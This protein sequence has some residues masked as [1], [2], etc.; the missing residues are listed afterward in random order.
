MAAPK[1]KIP[2][3]VPALV[4]H[5]RSTEKEVEGLISD[6]KALMVMFDALLDENAQLRAQLAMLAPV[7]GA[8]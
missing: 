3:T 7:A 4:A 6:A 2:R 8:A 5:I 1:I